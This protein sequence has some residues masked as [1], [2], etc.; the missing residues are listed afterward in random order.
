MIGIELVKNRETKEMANELTHAIL[1][2][3]V[4]EGVLFGES[5]FKGMGNV[6]KIKPPLVISESQADRVLEVFEKLLKK[7]MA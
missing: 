5:L 2:Q 4:D 6:L 1:T 7:N 3:A